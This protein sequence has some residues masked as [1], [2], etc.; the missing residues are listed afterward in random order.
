MTDTTRGRAFV[1]SE[2]EA[3]W[4][5]R[6]ASERSFQVDVDG[7]DRARKFYNLVEFPYPSAEGLHVGHAYTYCGADTFGRFRR[8]QGRAVFQPM[9]FDSFGIHT[10]NFALKV[11]E[12]PM[13]LTAR[14]IENYRRQL[15]QL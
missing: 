6:W 3:R 14:T 8:M 9:G 10:E 2:I 13:R 7:V 12:H 5:A 11:G 15:R 1:P 4:Q